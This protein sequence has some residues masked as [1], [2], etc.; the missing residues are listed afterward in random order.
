[1]FGEKMTKKLTLEQTWRH[2]LAMWKW[3]AEEAKQGST[4]DVYDLKAEWMDKHPQFGGI[5]VSC[6]FC[7]YDDEQ[8]CGDCSQ[9]PGRLVDKEFHCLYHETYHFPEKPVKFYQK[10]LELNKKR[11]EKK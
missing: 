7:H 5:I 3:I 10:L 9:C 2:C 8:G 11:K 4:W 1:M 6:F